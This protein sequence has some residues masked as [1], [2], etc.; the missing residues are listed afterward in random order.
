MNDGFVI[1]RSFARLNTLHVIRRIEDEMVV[2][3]HTLR[4]PRL[5][6]VFRQLGSFSL[7]RVWSPQAPARADGSLSPAA[8]GAGSHYA[9]TAGEWPRARCPQPRHQPLSSD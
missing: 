1:V 2:E 6:P 4:T 8:D 3:G 9:A 5:T 7:L